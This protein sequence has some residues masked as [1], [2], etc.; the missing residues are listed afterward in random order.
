MARPYAWFDQWPDRVPPVQGDGTAC[1]QWNEP[2]M[3]LSFGR[4]V[5]GP[6]MS[7]RSMCRIGQRSS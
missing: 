1:L 5:A 4:P 7:E 6:Y 2:E 3:S